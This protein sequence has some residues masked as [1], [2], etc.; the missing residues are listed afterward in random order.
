VEV[1]V[2]RTVNQNGIVPLFFA[3]VLS[4]DQVG[5]KAVARAEYYDN[6]PKGF[7]APPE[8]Q[9]LYILPFA[10]DQNAWDSLM[11][12]SGTDIW[13][14][15]PVTKQVTSGSDGIKEIN[16]Y[17]Q[18]TGSSGNSGTINIGTTNNG[19]ANLV[20]QIQQGL[21]SDDLNSLPN[22]QLALDE[23]GTRVLPGNP[24][25]SAGMEGALGEVV[26]PSNGSTPTP[27]I[28]PLYSTVTGSG[29][30]TLYTIVRF[31]GVR[32]VDVDLTGSKKNNKW[33]IVQP[34]SVLVST[35]IIPGNSGQSNNV[36]SNWSVRLVPIK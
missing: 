22:K 10:L 34:A 30:N 7:L 19:T 18:D 36:Y 16:I 3:R 31:V 35:G 26:K 27:R 12:G 29:A 28:L 32:I 13:S 5:S 15:D 17:P 20:R 11:A 14:I 9:Y 6:P 4:I 33:V 24:G 21:N 25:I 8:G 1:T 23:N 2:Q